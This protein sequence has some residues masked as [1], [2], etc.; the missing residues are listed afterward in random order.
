MVFTKIGKYEPD[1][2]ILSPQYG[3]RIVEVK[4]YS[5]GS[6]KNAHLNGLIM[7]RNDIT[8][9]SIQQA[10]THVE[11]LLHFLE[12]EFPHYFNGKAPIGYLVIHAGFT[13][14]EI[15]EESRH[16]QGE[17][18]Y[19]KHHMTVDEMETGLVGRVRAAAKFQR[20]MPKNAIDGNLKIVQ[21]REQVASES[22]ILKL[23][24]ESKFQELDQKIS[25]IGI[26]ESKAEC[27]YLLKQLRPSLMFENH[28]TSLF[29][30]HFKLLS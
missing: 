28:T 21:F 6:I 4:N 19:W 20:S 8:I 17:P 27:Q 12:R 13:R 11:G 29:S 23:E 9:N 1:L 15:E 7:Y 16:L 18:D 14:K 2:L 5:I 22:S 25:E 10:K 30:V 3:I 26:R 24:I